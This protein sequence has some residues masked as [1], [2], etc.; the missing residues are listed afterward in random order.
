MQLGQL[1]GIVT[2]MKSTMVLVVCLFVVNGCSP[3]QDL[4]RS[5]VMTGGEIRNL[6]GA[7]DLYTLDTGAPPGTNMGLEALIT[8]PGV[9]AWHGPYLRPAVLPKD[10]WGTVLRYRLAGSNYV[11]QSAGP[12]RKFDT[13]DDICM[14]QRVWRDP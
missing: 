7:I 6:V 10:S 4:E 12:D 13:P 9:S 5:K 1:I 3:V 2:R 11:I 8:D 14:T